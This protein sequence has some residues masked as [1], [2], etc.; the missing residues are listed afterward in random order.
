MNHMT[1]CVGRMCIINDTEYDHY[2]IGIVGEPNMVM[3]TSLISFCSLKVVE[4]I[5]WSNIL[6]I[7]CGNKNSDTNEPMLPYIYILP[8]NVI[9]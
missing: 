9:N 6:L 4:N 5:S 8:K 2:G 7:D 3:N 1:T